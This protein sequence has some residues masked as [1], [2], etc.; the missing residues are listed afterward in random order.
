VMNDWTGGDKVVPGAVDIHPDSLEYLWGFATGGLGRFVVQGAQ[1]TRSAVD[2]EFEPKKTPWVRSFYGQIDDQSQKTDYYTK[3]EPVQW[4]EGKLKEYA[5]GGDVEA[6]KKLAADYPAEVEAIPTFKMV[7]KQRRKI[8]K[9]RRALEANTKISSTE[10]QA[11]L[12][13][14]DEMELNAM[15]EARKAYVKAKKRKREE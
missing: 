1:T 2:G 13:K 14:L 6:H 12:D 11:K 15:A 10:R 3:R 9:E 8:N 5:D 4:V 7:E